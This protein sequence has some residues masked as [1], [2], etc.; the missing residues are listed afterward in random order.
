MDTPIG[1]QYPFHVLPGRQCLF[2]HLDN[3]IENGEPLPICST[4]FP[5]GRSK[6][7]SL[8]KTLFQAHWQR[9]NR[10]FFTP[11]PHPIFARVPKSEPRYSCVLV[12]CHPICL[13]FFTPV[14][15]RIGQQADVE[16]R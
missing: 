6:E 7:F 4:L 5:Q 14:I 15:A 8:R 2:F 12:H 13:S 16:K 11:A 9:N 10:V 1:S 3:E